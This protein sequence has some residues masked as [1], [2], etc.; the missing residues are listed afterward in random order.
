MAYAWRYV[1]RS[2]TATFGLTLVAFWVAAALLAPLLPLH[3][4]IA[5]D[6]AAL[7]YPY[8]TLNHWLGVDPKGRDMLARIVWGARIAL[9]LAPVSV[10][11]GYVIG[12]ALGTVAAYF[13]G[14]IDTV[15]SRLIDVILA[16]PV[17]VLYI[18][19]ITTVGPSA[20]NI[21]AA[22]LM[23]I[24]PAVAR[25]TRGLILE[26]KTRDFVAA[27]QL[28][29]ESSLYIMFVELLPN[30]RGPVILDACARF[31]WT[32]VLIGILGFLGVGL[33]PPTPD[34]GGMIREATNVLLVWPHMAIFPC[35]ALATLVIGFNLVADGIAE[36]SNRA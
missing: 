14:W 10:L 11:C 24:V 2:G 13:G 8:P 25:L 12:C 9:G 6:Y 32:I 16:F 26:L 19:L 7:N 4:P 28:R 34:W 35:I 18:L 30:A 3:D 17:L 22:A 33:P 20:L 36:L 27:A 15:A 5:I 1:R 31:G 21:V 29:G 23:S